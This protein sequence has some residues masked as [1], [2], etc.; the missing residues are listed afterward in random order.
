MWYIYA[1][2]TSLL[3]QTFELSVGNN[4]YFIIEESNQHILYVMHL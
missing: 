1:I 3:T 2:T 4:M